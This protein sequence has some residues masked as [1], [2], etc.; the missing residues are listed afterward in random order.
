MISGHGNIETAVSAIK[1]G[2]YDFIE[3][4]FKADRLVLVAERALEASRLKREVKELQ[5]RSRGRRA[6]IVG[7]SPAIEP[8]APD[9]RARRADQQ[10]RLITGAAGLRQ[11]TGG[12]HDPRAVGP[13]RRALRRLNAADHHARAHGERAVRRRGERRNGPRKVGALEEAHGGT[14]YLDEVAD[15]P[16]ETQSKIL[17]VLVDQNF[18]RVGG[19]TR[20]QVDVRII[21]STGRDLERG[22][23]RRAASARTS[24]IAWRGA[25]PGAGARRA[26]RGH[27]RARSP[28]SWSR[29]RV[30]PA[31]RSARSATTP[32]RCCRRMTGRATSASSAT[33][34]SG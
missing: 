25:D 22:D 9:H 8:A 23:R 15:M 7:M 3:K 16:R 18:Q 11:G 32:W 20:V 4:P 1:R 27:S 28:I 13:R 17:R 29:S 14:L 12:A 6:A 30:Q 34:S 33:M 19:A 21:S 10:P 2:A 26:A 31:C 24:F 5:R